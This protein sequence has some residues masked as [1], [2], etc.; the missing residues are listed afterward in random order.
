[1]IVDW[2]DLGRNYMWIELNGHQNRRTLKSGSQTDHIRT[3]MLSFGLNRPSLYRVSDMSLGSNWF[4]V[5]RSQ[6]KT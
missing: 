2:R 4:R 3:G 5:T 6:G 1:M